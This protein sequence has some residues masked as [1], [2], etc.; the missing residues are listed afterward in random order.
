MSTS[1]VRRPTA[2]RRQPRA[3][4]ELKPITFVLNGRPVTIK[5]RPGRTLLHILR[6]DLDLTGTKQACDSEGECGTCTVLLDGQAVR[7]CLTPIDKVSGR[8]VVTIEGL[9]TPERLHPVQQAFIEQGGVQCGFCTPGMI[10][11]VVALLDCEPDPSRDQIIAALEGN[12]CR[13]TGYTRIV[14]AVQS[15]AAV[16][17]GELPSEGQEGPILGGSQIRVMPWTR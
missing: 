7:S 9:G 6:E 12:L 13:C 3:A 16:L 2:V 8:T 15:A 17:R 10:L 4:A 14:E 11:S 5:T 1:T